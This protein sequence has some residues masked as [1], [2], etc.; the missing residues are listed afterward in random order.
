MRSSS[1][2]MASG[3]NAQSSDVPVEIVRLD[4][5]DGELKTTASA[6]HLPA[7]PTPSHP[8][9]GLSSPAID[10]GVDMVVSES[11]QLQTSASPRMPKIPRSSPGDLSCA[12]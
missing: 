8:I 10:P 6:H 5:R 2:R 3:A 11:N 1:L 4:R 9:V 7:T 12:G